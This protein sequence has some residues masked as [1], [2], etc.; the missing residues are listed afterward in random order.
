[1]KAENGQFGWMPTSPPILCNIY[2]A[3]RSCFLRVLAESFISTE[4]KNPCSDNFWL[5]SPQG[6]KDQA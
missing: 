1:M 3:V 4:S 2:A 6:S 5:V